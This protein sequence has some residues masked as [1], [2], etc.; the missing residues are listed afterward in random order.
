MITTEEDVMKARLHQ[1]AIRA[2]AS[3]T[4]T[5]QALFLKAKAKYRADLAA[6]YGDVK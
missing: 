6:I 5:T 4:K 1:Q 3:S 2:F